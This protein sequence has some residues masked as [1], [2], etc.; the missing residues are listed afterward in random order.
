[1]IEWLH[2][3]NYPELDIFREVGHYAFH[4]SLSTYVAVAAV[5]LSILKRIILK[6]LHW[7]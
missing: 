2:N 7:S 4:P 3:G 1:M 6:Y 5:I